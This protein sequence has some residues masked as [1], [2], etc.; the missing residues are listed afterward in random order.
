MLADLDAL[1]WPALPLLF[2]AGCCFVIAGAIWW[3]A[4]YRHNLTLGPD[5][6]LPPV[7]H[8]EH[9]LG[10]ELEPRHLRADADTAVVAR[11]PG[12]TRE[13]PRSGPVGNAIAERIPPYA[14]LTRWP[15]FS[16]PTVAL[17]TVP[18]PCPVEVEKLAARGPVCP[19]CGGPFG[20]CACVGKDDC[21]LTTDT[22]D[23]DRVST[24]PLYVEAGGTFDMTAK[25]Q[26]A[27]E[28]A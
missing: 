25:L 27:R 21:P 12:A 18:G 8:V 11:I 26:K 5:P 4:I 9:P 16:D 19:T 2:L 13:A 28:A 22:I 1:I 6:V 20:A 23:I 24:P 3:V 15:Q 7:V 14:D 10:V 17:R